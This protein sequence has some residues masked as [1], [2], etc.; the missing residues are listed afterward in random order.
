MPG[1]ETGTDYA[2]GG[3]ALISAGELGLDPASYF[4]AGAVDQRAKRLSEGSF[5]RVRPVLSASI[6]A[7]GN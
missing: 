2:G 3:V 1:T 7:E 4:D 5:D 6:I